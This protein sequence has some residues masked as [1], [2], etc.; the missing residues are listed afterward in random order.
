MKITDIATQQKN[1]D[2]VNIY[3]DGQFAFGLHIEVLLQHRLQKNQEVTESQVAE[4]KAADAFRQAYD[5]SLNFLS[6]RPRSSRE[7]LQYLRQKLI[8]KHPDYT[9]NSQSDSRLRFIAEQQTSI[10]QVMARL[11]EAGYIDDVAFARWWITNR[12]RFRP[13]GKRLLL[14][15]LKAK[16]VST[17]D[18]EA[19]LMTPR[20]EG[21][22]SSEL[23]EFNE[24]EAATQ[25]ATK[26]LKKHNQLSNYE[27]KQKLSRY[28]AG[29]GFD[30]DVINQVTQELLQDDN[31][32]RL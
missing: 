23:T 8:Y 20:E 17:A 19:A 7:I 18:I 11:T 30:W 9:H 13:R 5:K 27:Q 2:R 15:E 26:Y 29:R 14:L 22:F 25:L 10:E 31:S 12:Q 4:L 6:V 21:H 28:L 16:G 1:G 32:K 24:A 3:V